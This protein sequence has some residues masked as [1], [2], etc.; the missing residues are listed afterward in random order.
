MNQRL[1]V[2]LTGGSGAP[3]RPLPRPDV[4]IAADSGLH[5]AAELGLVVDLVV[6]DFDSARP[7][8][9]DAAVSAGAELEHHPADKEA[10]DLDLALD[11]AARRGATRTIVV[12]GAGDD[13]IDHVLANAGVIAAER[14]R[15]VAPEWWVGGARV[16][17]VRGRSTFAGGA[18]YTVSILPMG[19]P[20]VVSTFGLRWPLARE[21]LDFGSSRGVSNRMT[22]TDATVEVHSGI[23]MVA[24]LEEAP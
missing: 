4:V 9:V 15:S 2:I 21:T 14:H 13:R 17:P 1:C 22:S 24:L 5:L 18:G 20:V 12:G 3:T 23:A 7:D 11:A 8:L 10:T 16:W 6:G 19:G